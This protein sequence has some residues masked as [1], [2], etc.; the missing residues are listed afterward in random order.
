MELGASRLNFDLFKAQKE[1]LFV[2]ISIALKA[3]SVAPK[4]SF[5]PSFMC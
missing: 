4:V 2:F 5:E 1:K 3:D